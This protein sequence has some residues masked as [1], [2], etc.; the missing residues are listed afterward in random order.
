MKGGEHGEVRNDSCS[1]NRFKEKNQVFPVIKSNN[2]GMVI[3][4]TLYMKS[5]AWSAGHI[6][7]L[8]EQEKE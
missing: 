7:D 2:S 3:R 1:F 5:A 6:F 4:E 8:N